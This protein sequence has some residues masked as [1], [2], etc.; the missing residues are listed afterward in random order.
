MRPG[1]IY[2]HADIHGASSVVI[3]NPTGEP[4]PPK[5]LNEAGVMAICYSV[6]WD[7]KVVTTAWWVHSEQ[8][9]KT[10]PTGEYLSAGSFMVRGKKNFLPPGNLVMGFS[11]L[12][13]LEES[14][15]FRHKDE[16]RVRSLEDEMS[17][18]SMSEEPDEEVVLSEG[19]D[20]EDEDDEK[21]E[22]ENK[23]SLGVIEE[24]EKD[25]ES[26]EDDNG[27]SF[28]DTEIKIHHTGKE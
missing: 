11:F 25:E 4:V 6:A 10:A 9:S 17:V 28:P 27:I 7:A 24:E 21:N 12:F 14:S 13:K 16:R 15:V 19:D 23:D 1:D 22:E 18:S 5:T 8:V 20:D 2:V 26:E 3:K